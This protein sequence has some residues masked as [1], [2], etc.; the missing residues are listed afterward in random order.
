MEDIDNL[1]HRIIA[2]AMKVYSIL[3]NGF[4]EVICQRALAIEFEKQGLKFAR[5]LEMDILYDGIL[6]G[7]RRVDF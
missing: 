4:Q 3:G 7:N 6:A 2:C 5:E 1:T